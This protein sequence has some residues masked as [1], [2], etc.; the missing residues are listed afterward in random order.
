MNP[1]HRAER[2]QPRAFAA[3]VT[4]IGAAQSTELAH[5]QDDTCDRDHDRSDVNPANQIE[6][7]GPMCRRAESPAEGVIREPRERAEDGEEPQPPDPMSVIAAHVEPSRST[8][9]K[10]SAQMKNPPTATK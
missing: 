3:N 10:I 2:D 7:H 9:K 8:G 1:P 5:G 4:I 6:M